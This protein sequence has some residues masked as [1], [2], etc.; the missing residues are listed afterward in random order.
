MRKSRSKRLSKKLHKSFLY[1][2]RYSISLSEEWR[3]KLFEAED[4]ATFKIKQ[5]PSS[6]LQEMIQK[7]RLRFCVMRKSIL[8]S[9]LIKFVFFPFDF[10]QVWIESENPKPGSKEEQVV[11]TR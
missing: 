2:I 4:A 3:K 6:K 1:D 11:K 10:P 5:V 7:Y 8:N 9:E